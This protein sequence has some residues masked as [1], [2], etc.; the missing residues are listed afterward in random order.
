MGAWGPAIFSDD[1]AQDIR[2]EYKYLLMYRS[3]EESEQKIFDEFYSDLTNSDEESVFWFALALCEWKY[4]RLTDKVKNKALEFISN[5]E[6]LE[7]WRD[8][9]QQVL[10]KRETDIK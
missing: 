4:G 10:K 8:E 7:R 6:D 5:G 9:G 1:I 2:T 3:D